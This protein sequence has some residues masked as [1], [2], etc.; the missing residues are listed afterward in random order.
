MID[1]KRGGKYYRV[2]KPEWSDPLDPAFAKRHGGRWTP[3][4]EFGAVYLNASIDVAAA[5]ARCSHARRAVG[6]FDLRPD[7]R[8]WL[9]EVDVPTRHVVDVVT[10]SGIAAAGLPKTYP[11]GAS[12]STCWPIARR[13]Y[14]DMDEAGIAS[15]SNAE[16]TPLHCV[17]EE[18]AWFDRSQ[19]VTEIAKRDFASWYPGPIP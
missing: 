4:G 15:L 14:A 1:I 16:C 12:H 2:F 19:P 5:N 13:A 7:R 8:P 9:M 6:L 18:L 17:G 3:R 10:P 11:L